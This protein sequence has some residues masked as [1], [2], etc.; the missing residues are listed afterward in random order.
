MLIAGSYLTLVG[1]ENITSGILAAENNLN[2]LMRTYF[3]FGKC[4]TVTDIT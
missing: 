1:C 3:I 2:K 4:I